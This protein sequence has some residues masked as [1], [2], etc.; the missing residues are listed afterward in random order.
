M[1]GRTH[2]LHAFLLMAC[3]AALAAACSREPL[4]PPAGVSAAVNSNTGHWRFNSEKYS[5]DGSRPTIGRSGLAAVQAEVLYLN[6]RAYLEVYSFAVGN[7]DVPAGDMDRLVI[8]AYTSSGVAL[9]SQTVV[10]GRATFAFFDTYKNL[11]PGSVLELTVT[12]S[13]LGPGHSDVVTVAPVVVRRAPAL[14]V[15]GLSVPSIVIAGSPTVF[16]ATVAETDGE[17]GARMDCSLKVNGKPVDVAHGIWVDA[18]DVVSCAFTYTFPAAGSYTVAVE[19]DNITP[20]PSSGTKASQTTTVTARAPAVLTGPSGPIAVSYSASVRSGTFASVDSF[21]TT[22]TARSTGQLFYE[23]RSV[24]S[25]NGTDQAA[26]LSGSINAPVTFPLAGLE[27]RQSTAGRLVHSAAFTNLAATVGNG[28][29]CVSQG[30]GSGVEFY[31]CSY[32]AGFTTF[33]YLRSAGTV[34]YFSSEYTKQWNGAA[35]DEDTYVSNGTGTQGAY[36][37]FG[38]SFDFDV[39]MSDVRGTYA[40]SVSVPLAAFTDSDITP[41]SCTNGVFTI[42]PTVYDVHTCTASSYVFS[43]IAG[44]VSGSGV[45]AP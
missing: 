43:G 8:R 37:A 39:R 31:L 13:G 34:T 44:S 42:P 6:G 2:R 35:Y 24:N 33:T 14:A 30:A 40:A 32:S 3:T 26:V 18:G 10:D 36:V 45:T 38:S 7:L 41:S 1:T 27:L 19:L 5:D 15:T 23:A 22:W 28:V 16:A 11:L 4:A 17:R 25:E 20:D 9:F 21:A 12:V 29:S